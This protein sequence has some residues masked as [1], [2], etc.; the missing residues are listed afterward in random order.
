[1]ADMLGQVDSEAL[2]FDFV[3]VPALA[4][5]SEAAARAAMGENTDGRARSWWDG[6]AVLPT[7]F[8]E[9][10]GVSYAWDV[11]M[12]FP[13]GVTWEEALADG[14]A[15]LEHQ[16]WE[17]PSESMLDHE[18]FQRAVEDCLPVCD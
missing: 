16:L 9:P 2:R 5:D 10:L 17:L 8:A 6:E 14:P 1:M 12:L 4:G 11:Y 7:A 18:R 13:P 15:Y 3:W